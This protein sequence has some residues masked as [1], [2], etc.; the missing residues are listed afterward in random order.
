MT[1]GN[2]SSVGVNDGHHLHQQICRSCWR[3]MH[4][5]RGLE[6]HHESLLDL[7]IFLIAVREDDE[8]IS[9]SPSRVLELSATCDDSKTMK[10]MTRNIQ[11]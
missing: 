7:V 10:A 5:L 11:C 2:S 4:S 6:S 1:A 9:D 3:K 8:T